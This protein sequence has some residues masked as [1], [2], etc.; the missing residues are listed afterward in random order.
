MSALKNEDITPK[1]I[2]SVDYIKCSKLYVLDRVCNMYFRK[3][4]N[5]KVTSININEQ[6]LS[7]Q[8]CA[9]NN[10]ISTIYASNNL[11]AEHW[12][13]ILNK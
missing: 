3:F 6:H 10:K 13:F 9:C 12:V 5:I 2:E 11:V 7:L 1:V 4:N 8:Q